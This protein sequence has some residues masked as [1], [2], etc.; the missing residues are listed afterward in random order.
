MADDFPYVLTE[1]AATMLAERQIPLDW[2]ARVLATPVVTE[3]DRSD[4]E[5][6]HALARIPEH[7]DRVLRVIYNPQTQPWRIVTVYFDRRASRQL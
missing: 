1:H 6:R 7:G 3:A 5:L 2:V 4:P